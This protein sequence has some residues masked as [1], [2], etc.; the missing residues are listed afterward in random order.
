MIAS[1]CAHGHSVVHA[2]ALAEAAVAPAL[3][4]T[5][6]CWPLTAWAVPHAEHIH[7]AG[8]LRPHAGF[9]VT[10]AGFAPAPVDPDTTL[11]VAMASAERIAS[12][13]PA[14]VSMTK[15]VMW[16]NLHAASLDHALALES[17]T[18]ALVR[19]TAD[20]AEARASFIEKRAPS[21]TDPTT[22]R[23]VR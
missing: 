6:R 9:F 10:A 4:F 16:A 22:P 2:I 23:K 12:L 3:Q 11:A 21:F 18:Q 5:G 7:T 20:A 17:R 15:E 1:G 14:A 19:T 13:A 8:V